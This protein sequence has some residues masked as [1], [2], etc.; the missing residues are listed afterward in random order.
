M[1]R[2][3][4]LPVLVPS[5]LLDKRLLMLFS[6]LL[7]KRLLM[8]FHLYRDFPFNLLDVHYTFCDRPPA[9]LPQLGAV[10]NLPWNFW[11]GAADVGSV[12]LPLAAGN[13][14]VPGPIVNPGISHS[15]R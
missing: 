3:L 14:S 15:G 12:V 4:S 2:I 7:D 11:L 1:L 6:R 8:L 13:W 9:I 10:S 5:S